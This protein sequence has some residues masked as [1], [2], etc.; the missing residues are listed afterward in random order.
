MVRLGAVPAHA[1]LAAR[2]ND[3]RERE[4]HLLELCALPPHYFFISAAFNLAAI[5]RI[6]SL[7]LYNLAVKSLEFCQ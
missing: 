3:P 4:K 7:I 1:S 2:R 5:G 6:S